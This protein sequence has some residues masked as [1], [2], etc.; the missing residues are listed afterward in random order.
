MAPDDRYPIVI[1]WSDEDQA[2]IADVPDLI[3]C[4]AHGRTPEMALAEIQRAQ[5]AWLA[6]ARERGFPIPEPSTRLPLVARSA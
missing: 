6:V 5:A 4:S 3:P 2:S 1:F